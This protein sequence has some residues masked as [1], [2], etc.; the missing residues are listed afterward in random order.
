MRIR[1]GL[2]AA[3]CALALP[4]P[5]H[6]MAVHEAPFGTMPTGEPVKVVTLE[7]DHGMRVRVLTY[8]GTLQTI[9][10][11]DR[12]GHVQDIVLGFGDLSHYL[13]EVADGHLYFGA[14]IGRYANRIAYGR[15]TLDGH[16]YQVPVSLP[17]HTLHG[18]TKGFDKR[19]WSIVSTSHDAGGAHLT[20]GL[21]SRDG[22]QGFPG[23]MHVTVDYTLDDQD[24]LTLHFHATTDKPTVVS[25]TSHS[26]W[27]LGGEASGSIEN[28][29]I[30][31]NADRYTPTDPTGIP[32]GEIAS[33]AHTPYDLRRPTRIGTHLRDDDPQLDMDRGYD[34][35]FVIDGAANQAPRLAAT[36]YSPRSGR[37]MEVW[38]T[39]PGLQFYTSNGLDGRYHGIS[40]HA[41]RQTDAV[42]LETEAF[43]DSPNHPQFPSVVLRPGA[44]YDST[45]RFH[46]SVVP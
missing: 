15:F 22:D 8:G 41:Y 27:N 38:T 39:Q 12:D 34:K 19:L 40:G 31:I 9:E 16:A 6:A 25:L 43:P 37:Q 32:T 33:V 13:H 42:S 24:S 44:A 45:T 11:P 17:P 3:L 7:N 21:V 26:F 18:G 46:F 29:V 4:L 35:N 5:A 23:T 30:R 20:L 36:L 2:C 28:D 1:Q 10:V 14:M